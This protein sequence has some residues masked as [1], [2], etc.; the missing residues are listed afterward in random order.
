MPSF[1]HTPPLAGAGT[2]L[3]VIRNF[4]VPRKIMFSALHISVSKKNIYK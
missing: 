4:Y 1:S 3:P 2:A